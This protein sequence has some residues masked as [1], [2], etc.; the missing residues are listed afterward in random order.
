MTKA[1]LIGAGAT[2]AEYPDAPLTSDFFK[3]L[4]IHDHRLY[5]A[6]EQIILPHLNLDALRDSN[7]EDVMKLAEE[8]SPSVKNSF[9]REV[10][11]A[12]YELLAENT[13][14]TEASVLSALNKTSRLPG[15]LFH[16]L[17]NDH[18]LNEQDF[19]MTLNYDLYLDK[20][21]LRMQGT[22][23]YGITGDIE[24]G[25]RLNLD[26]HHKR[27]SV[28]HLHGA[29]N[30]QR[31]SD[32]HIAISIG[33]ITPSYVRTGPNLYLVPPGKKEMFPIL[34][35]IWNTAEER[36]PNIDEL[37]IIGSS[38]NPQDQ[39]LIRL[40]KYFIKCKG[41]EKIKIIDYFTHDPNLSDK[42]T[43]TLGRGYKLYPYGFY[44]NN[45][46]GYPGAI[47]FIFSEK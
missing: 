5:R 2:R 35:R 45:P 19:F 9:L 21:I 16:T 12:I 6:I 26:Y 23:D 20:E 4:E 40:I 11:L 14:S 36:I 47:E 43:T 41:I 37:I 10:Y 13:G 1:F 34:K 17:V 29:L 42:Y 18:R 44:L 25:S 30:W 15:T 32:N 33:A 46:R 22:I 28:Y 38:L 3:L 31:I 7:I 27:Y 39:E 8:F 24:H